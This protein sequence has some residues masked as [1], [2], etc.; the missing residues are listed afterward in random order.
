MP[1][2]LR[3]QPAL[4]L[5]GLCNE[6]LA[7]TRHSLGGTLVSSL[8]AAWGTRLAR[9]AGTPCMDTAE[10]RLARAAGGEARVLLAR[11][12]G[13]MNLSGRPAALLLRDR[14]V[15]VEDVLLAHDGV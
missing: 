1:P 8:A 15:P 4:V 2:S 6:G 14:G 7:G 5:I 12:R 3:L 13:F 11:P 10:V 9:D